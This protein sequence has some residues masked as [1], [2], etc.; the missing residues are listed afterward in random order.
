MNP[1]LGDKMMAQKGGNYAMS[2]YA[3]FANKNDNPELLTE[4]ATWLIQTLRL[5]HFENRLL[6][7]KTW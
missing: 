5:D 2:C 6:K 1:S 3:F 4:A 7:V